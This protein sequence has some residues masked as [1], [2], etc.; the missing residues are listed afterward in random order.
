MVITQI[1]RTV[2]ESMERN[3]CNGLLA[4]YGKFKKEKRWELRRRRRHGNETDGGGEM[5]VDVC[6]CVMETTEDDGEV[7]VNV[8]VQAFIEA[9]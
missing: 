1:L 2:G 6:I 8:N 5:G 3:V 9:S 4:D 7:S